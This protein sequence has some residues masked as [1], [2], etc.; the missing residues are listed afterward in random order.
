MWWECDL[1]SVRPNSPF[2]LRRFGLNYSCNQVCVAFW[3]MNPGFMVRLLSAFSIL[4]GRLHRFLPWSKSQLHSCSILKR[5]Q[6][7]AHRNMHLSKTQDLLPVFCF[8]TALLCAQMHLTNTWTYFT[9]FLV[10]HLSLHRA[11][12]TRNFK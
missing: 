7:F 6:C 3:V 11:E 9:C 4:L 12:N 1:T 5:F 10:M 8:F 2:V